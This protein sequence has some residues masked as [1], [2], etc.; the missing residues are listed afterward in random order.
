VANAAVFM[1]L[2]FSGLFFRFRGAE[3]SSMSWHSFTAV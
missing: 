1:T 2:L 3:L